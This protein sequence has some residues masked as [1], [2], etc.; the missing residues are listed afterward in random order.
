M[1]Q[2]SSETYGPPMEKDMDATDYLIQ[3]WCKCMNLEKEK[4]HFLAI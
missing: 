4:P 2:L 3:L 1:Y